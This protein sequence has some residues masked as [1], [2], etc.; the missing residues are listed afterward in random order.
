V[1]LLWGATN[2]EVHTAAAA[3]SNMQRTTT[4]TLACAVAHPAAAAARQ[5]LKL[6]THHHRR[7]NIRTRMLANLHRTSNPRIVINKR[8]F[9][10][11]NDAAA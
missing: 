10:V 9:G 2:R 6:V 4:R 7:P 11:K 8:G 3:A 1:L 5:K